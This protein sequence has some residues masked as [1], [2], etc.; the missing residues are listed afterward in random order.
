[1]KMIMT[2]RVF[3]ASTIVVG[4][5]LML[6]PQGAKTPIKIEPFKVIASV[7]EVLF[8]KNGDAPSAS[9]FGATNYLINVSSH[10]SFVK[11]DLLFLHE[12]AQKLIEEEPDFLT[13]HFDEQSK[14]IEEFSETKIGKNWLSFLLF[15]TI[16]AL[17][18]DPI[19]GGNKNELGWRWLGHN[20][21]EPQ[22][23][24][25]WAFLPTKEKK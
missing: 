1:M 2:R 13:M 23:T 4:T 7:Q 18:S 21:G 12:G 25:A 3:I 17:L 15:Y 16:E 14:V 19:Y 8:P 10:A 6:L 24:V 20:T 9:E 11:S 22:P 5:A